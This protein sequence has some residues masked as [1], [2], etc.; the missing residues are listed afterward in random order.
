MSGHTFKEG[1]R[2][3]IVADP[4]GTCAEFGNEVGS[5]TTIYLVDADNDG[6]IWVNDVDTLSGAAGTC[7]SPDDIEPA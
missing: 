3:R 6:A 7:V 2:V 4:D 1:D 5:V